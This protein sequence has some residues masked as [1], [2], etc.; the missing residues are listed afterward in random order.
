MVNDTGIQDPVTHLHKRS[1]KIMSKINSIKI[2][3]FFLPQNYIKK[4]QKNI[5]HQIPF[6][7]RDCNQANWKIFSLIKSSHFSPSKFQNLPN[8]SCADGK[9]YYNTLLITATFGRCLE[10]EHKRFVCWYYERK[11]MGHWWLSMQISV[12]YWLIKR[13]GHWHWSCCILIGSDN[14]KSLN[15]HCKIHCR[16]L[17]AVWWYYC[18]FW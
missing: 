11:W 1:M 12:M 13:N 14:W 2:Y 10:A 4:Q 17:S 7:N 6:S 8:N 15:I 18:Y 9:Y 3:F 5:H 16:F